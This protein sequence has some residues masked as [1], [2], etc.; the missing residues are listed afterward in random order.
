MK[1]RFLSFTDTG[2]QLARRIA[3]EVSGTVSRCNR[4]QSLAE[5]TQEGF[6]GA[7]A[8]VYVGAAGIAV[9]AIAPYLTSKVQDP[10]VVVV[11]ECG[12][13][14][15]PI[16]SGHLG[17]A[18]DL[19]RDISRTCGAQAVIT[20]A[21]DVHGIFAADEWAKRQNCVVCNPE[22]IKVVSGKLL[23]GGKIRVFSDWEI[24]GR[25]PKNVCQ[26]PRKGC[27]VAVSMTAQEGLWLLPRIIV[28]GIGCRK[29]TDAQ[30]IEREFLRF[31]QRNQLDTRCVCAVASIDLKQNEQ[32]LL[33]FC[34]SHSWELKTFC[35]QQL[36]EV[37]G[38]FEASEFVKT[39][40]GVDN[41][42]ERSAVLASGG[43]LYCPKQAG[44]GVT[45]AAACKFYQ[46][47][48]RWQDE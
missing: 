26:S 28:L 48:W 4:P 22:Q 36:R 32:G 13:F 45:I 14:A 16:A 1:I 46:P 8:L 29:G 2:E 25:P 37:P 12:K 42:C 15:I 43:A 41:I 6:S 39:I 11:D 31:C 23:R 47:N 30:R 9:R 7:D 24:V 10:A 40:T 38:Q 21:T 35:A 20:T 19:A 18:N 44:N 33:D 5:W 3:K 27:D 34:R 17:G